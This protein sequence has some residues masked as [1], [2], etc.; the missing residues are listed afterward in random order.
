MPH[1]VVASGKTCT[2]AP[3]RNAAAIDATVA[4]S[5][6]NLRRSMKTAP[7]RRATGP[8]TG[9]PAISTLATG[10]RGPPAASTGM[11]SHDM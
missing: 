1:L 3:A 10:T 7:T 9:Q 8:M 2:Q 6:R 4:G 5:D 11:S